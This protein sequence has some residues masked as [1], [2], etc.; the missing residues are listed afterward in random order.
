MTPLRT[1]HLAGYPLRI[2]A[3]PLTVPDHPWASFHDLM[4]LAEM[5]EV[6]QPR[7]LDKLRQELPDMVHD[8]PDGTVIVAEPMVG[9][10]F[11][12]LDMMGL[13]DM[14]DHPLALGSILRRVKT[15]TMLSSLMGW[16]KPTPLCRTLFT[17]APTGHVRNTVSSAGRSSARGSPS[18]SPSHTDQS[19]GP[20]T[21]GI[22]S[23]IGAIVAIASVVMMAK[24]HYNALAWR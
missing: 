11:Q 9:G 15:P 6:D 24:L 20:K 23:C 13:E 1:I 21:I 17:S 19:A 3:S 7:W 16:S 14:Q 5:D 18:S 22:R 10:V 4:T 12:A 8:L 2:Y